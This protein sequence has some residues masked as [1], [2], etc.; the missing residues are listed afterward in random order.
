MEI[1]NVSSICIPRVFDNIGQ[2]RIQE[3]FNKLN[4]FIIDRI[5]VVQKQNEKGEK[6]KRVFVHIREWLQHS[7]AQKAKER[8]LAGKELKIVYDDP[9]FWKV[10][11]NKWVANP[12]P[13]HVPV[14]KPKIRIDYEEDNEVEK[15]ELET[16][17]KEGNRPYKD[18]RNDNQYRKPVHNKP[19]PMDS[20]RNNKYERKDKGKERDKD[21]KKVSDEKIDK[22]EEKEVKEDKVE[23]DEVKMEKEEKV[24]EIESIIQ[25]PRAIRTPEQKEKERRANALLA[26]ICS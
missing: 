5:D 6:F 10:S 17:G 13:K 20:K 14:P 4:I 25:K 7:D 19:R 11:I 9:W 2:D 3:V 1:N 18:S 24:E 26:K 21:Y 23:K 15:K 16:R 8:L 12:K 22:V